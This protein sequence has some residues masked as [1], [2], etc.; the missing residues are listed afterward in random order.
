MS[1]VS[2]KVNSRQVALVV[3]GLGSP[4]LR[5]WRLAV[6]QLMCLS[7]LTPKHTGEVIID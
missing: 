1:R 6:I 5:R 3:E 7:T 4:H 2:K